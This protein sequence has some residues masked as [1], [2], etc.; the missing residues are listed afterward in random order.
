MILPKGKDQLTACCPHCGL[1]LL[2]D[3]TEVDSALAR[4]YLYGRMV[5]VYQ[6]YYLVASDVSLCC[7]PTVLCFAKLAD[8]EKFSLGFGGHVMDFSQALSHL[9]SSHRHSHH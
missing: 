3:I 5:N 4:D 6:A 1:M 9:T 7:E 2:S 8:A